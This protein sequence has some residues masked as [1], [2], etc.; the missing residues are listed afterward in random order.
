LVNRAPGDGDE[1]A[2]KDDGEDEGGRLAKDLGA[3]QADKEVETV[4]EARV[5]KT[6][7]PTVCED[8]RGVHKMSIF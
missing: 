6:G 7:P 1:A 4:D 8:F 3:K 5:A 2:G